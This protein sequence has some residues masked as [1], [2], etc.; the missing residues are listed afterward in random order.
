MTNMD[1]NLNSIVTCI[2]R[3]WK[4]LRFFVNIYVG[5][6]FDALEQNVNFE[7]KIFFQLLFY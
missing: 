4:I 7:S 5:A 3:Q 2:G 6:G 1:H